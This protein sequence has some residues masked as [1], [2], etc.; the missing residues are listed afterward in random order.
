MTPPPRE[1][2]RGRGIAMTKAEFDDFLTGQRTCRIATVG[3][4]GPHLTAL[5]YV[6]DGTALWLTSVVRS[7]RWTDLQR[8]PR[9]AVLVDTGE[10]YGE[11]RGAELRGTVEIVGEV[12]RTGVPDERLTGPELLFA[13][14]YRGEDV[15]HHDGRHAWLRLVPDAIISWDFRKINRQRLSA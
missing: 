11:L 6:W 4:R 7:Q 2:R 14:K 1:Q 12:P 15:M 3:S 5:W 10:D 13:R 9:V 8:D